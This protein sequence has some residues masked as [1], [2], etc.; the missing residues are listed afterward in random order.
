MGLSEGG[1]TNLRVRLVPGGALSVKPVF[2]VETAILWGNVEEI[3]SCILKI[4][5]MSKW[6]PHLSIS[7]E[8]CNLKDGSPVRNP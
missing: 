7:V 3:I 8:L 1:G 2:L 6:C 5:L 4:A